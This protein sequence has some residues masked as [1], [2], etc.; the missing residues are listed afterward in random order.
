MGVDLPPQSPHSP[1]A[2]FRYERS[3]SHEERRVSGTH[4]R[5]PNAR[6]GAP[7]ERTRGDRPSQDGS[8]A[9]RPRGSGSDERGRLSSGEWGGESYP[10]RGSRIPGGSTLVRRDNSPRGYPPRGQQQRDPQTRGAYTS[11]TGHSFRS[12]EDVD[13][14]ANPHQRPNPARKELPAPLPPLFDRSSNRHV[15]P[16]TLSRNGLRE[17]LL[18]ARAEATEEGESWDPLLL[19]DEVRSWAWACHL[20]L[21]AWRLL[22]AS[23]C[24]SASWVCYLLPLAVT[25]SYL[26]P[27]AYRLSLTA[28]CSLLT[29]HCSLLTAHCLLFT[30]HYSLPTA[31]GSLFTGHCSLHNV[32]C[33]LLTAHCSLIQPTS[34]YSLLTTYS[35]GRLP[36]RVPYERWGGTRRGGAPTHAR[37]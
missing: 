25:Y 7:Y 30:A 1:R 8:F 28:H 34:Y 15:S 14:P 27:A 13:N 17:A 32:L 35:A 3:F 6:Q 18:P 2:A 21:G 22:P 24:L 36:P 19:A 4:S 9:W 12:R 5:M 20:P 26:L 10:P 11:R 29:A 33:S 37:P 31:H 16:S 23:C